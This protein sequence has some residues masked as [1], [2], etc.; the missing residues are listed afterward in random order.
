VIQYQKTPFLVGQDEARAQEALDKIEAGVKQR[1]RVKAKAGGGPLTLRAYGAAW[2]QKRLDKSAASDRHTSAADELRT[3]ERYVYGAVVEGVKLGDLLLKDV[4]TIHIRELVEKLEQRKSLKG[5]KL[6]ARTVCRTH[7]TLHTL[8]EHARADELVSSNPCDLPVG[9]LPERDD[10]NPTW[11]NTAIFFREEVEQLISAEEIPLDRRVLYALLFMGGGRWGETVAFTWRDWDPTLKPLG[12][13]DVHK[14]FSPRLRRTKSTKTGKQRLV[15]VIPTLARILAEWKLSGW[16]AMFGRAPTPD[17]LIVPKAPIY[18]HNNGHPLSDD[19]RADEL[20]RVRDLPPA[21]FDAYRQSRMTLKNFHADCKAIGLRPRRIHD[22]RRTLNSLLV[23][24]K[25]RDSIRK[26]IVWGPT[27]DISD[28]YT[29]LPWE[30]FCEEMVKLKIERREGKVFELRGA[31]L[32][33]DLNLAQDSELVTHSVT[34]SGSRGNDSGILAPTT[35]LERVAT[36]HLDADDLRS[37]GENA[38]IPGSVDDGR[39]DVRTPHLGQKRAACHQPGYTHLAALRGA[40]VAY[41]ATGDGARLARAVESFL[42]KAKQLP[43]EEGPA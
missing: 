20:S 13:L 43:A 30:T 25:A 35:G 34:R 4:R 3:L 27:K 16:P 32:V 24:D 1:I 23:V 39:Q 9:V 33:H 41:R 42:V 38:S 10:K 14:S 40:L 6:S 29:T 31:N 12:R 8:F 36:I 5:G 17:D 21:C 15:P 18:T 2:V 19:E 7:G 11:R 26:A 37:A 22:T 28:I